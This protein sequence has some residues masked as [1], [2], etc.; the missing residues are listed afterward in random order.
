M[1]ISGGKGSVKGC[2]VRLVKM[3]T[4]MLMQATTASMA[5]KTMK[6]SERIVIVRAG[7]SAAAYVSLPDQLARM[8]Y[9]PAFS[10]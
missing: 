4:A 2:E 5:V 7:L 3:K 8:S 1:G 9:M 6:K 10:R